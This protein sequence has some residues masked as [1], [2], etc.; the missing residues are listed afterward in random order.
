[1]SQSKFIMAK[2][3]CKVQKRLMEVKIEE[4]KMMFQ[5]GSVKQ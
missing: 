4:F 3:L 1:M 5:K 2:K